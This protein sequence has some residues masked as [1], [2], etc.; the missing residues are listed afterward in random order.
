MIRTRLSILFII[1]SFSSKAGT[2]IKYYFNHPVDNSLSTTINAMYLSNCVADTLVAYINRAKYSIDIAQ[3]DYNQ[4]NS[5]NIATAINNAYSRGVQVRWIYDGSSPNT[6]L[7][8]LN[9]SIHTLGSP[10]SNGYGIMHNKFVTIDANSS[11][12]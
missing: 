3:Y 8:L 6:A 7:S 5:A 2:K 1:F 4:G 11:D 9:S 10:T 12:P